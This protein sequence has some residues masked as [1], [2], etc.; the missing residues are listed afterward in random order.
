MNYMAR[1]EARRLAQPRKRRNSEKRPT[2]HPR[3]LY[4]KLTVPW[5]NAPGRK[6]IHPK[7]RGR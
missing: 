3:E 2:M 4:R 5:S 1:Q 7:E 6:R